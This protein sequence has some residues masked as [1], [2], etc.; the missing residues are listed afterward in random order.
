MSTNVKVAVRLRPFNQ[1][2]KERNAALCME[3]PTPQQTIITN[4]ETSK[5]YTYTFDHS[6]WLDTPQEV[7]YTDLGVPLLESAF[8]GYNATIFAYG[9]TGAG[10]SYSMTGNE[11]ARGIIPQMNK[12][13]FAKIEEAPSSMKY[14]VTV[15]FLEIYREEVK[16]LLNPSGKDLKVREHPKL[17][18]Y[19]EHLAELVVKSHQDVMRL[20]DQ[21]NHIRAVASTNMNDTSSR[22]HSVFTVKIAAKDED[23]EH[24]GYHAKINLVDLAGS[25]RQASTGATGDRLKEGA[26]I[27]KSLS[28]LGNVIN[29]LADPKKKAKFIPYRDS[30][31]TRILQESLGGNTKTVMLAALSPADINFDETHSTLQYANRAKNICNKAVKNEDENAR[32]IR[33]LREEVERLRKQVSVEGGGGVDVQSVEQMEKAI[34]DLKRAKQETWEQKE[35]LSRE[36][37]E[38]RKKTLKEK[39]LMELLMENL[40]EENEKL[41]KSMEAMREEKDKALK[42]YSTKK[43]MVETEKSSLQRDVNAYK[44]LVAQNATENEKEALL[45]KIKNSKHSLKRSSEEMKTAKKVLKAIT[46][47][48]QKCKEDIQ[49][50]SLFLQGDNELMRKL[51][52]EEVGR[53]EEENA[54]R[55][56]MERER[57]RTELEEEKARLKAEMDQRALGGVG[58]SAAEHLDL[59]MRLIEE[60][61]QISM[62][63]SQNQ[64]LEQQI[65]DLEV[66]LETEVERNGLRLERQ[67]LEYFKLFRA[68]RRYYEE[69]RV[70]LDSRYRDL[71]G[72]CINDCVELSKRKTELEEKL[73]RV[74][75]VTGYTDEEG[76]A[77]WA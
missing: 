48:Q 64:A 46:E 68:Y 56:E 23:N 49:A 63:K 52:D 72:R 22:S 75:A 30:K 1:R 43:N 9:Q 70:K 15:S 41:K 40:R 69:E 3:M 13:I 62:L 25:E 4:P 67:E 37:E 8:A 36:M 51:H 10:K 54:A 77:T 60:R 55:M 59:E 28:A 57:M 34:D 16:D 44:E 12:D 38:E 50:Q 53:L 21:G 58:I 33:E 47:K 45:Q 2:E 29:A 11:S 71:V 73:Q 19:V 26:A 17:G 18:V 7:V 20:M 32:I 42:D 14:L 39:G 76:E 66:S 6:Y 24:G 27:N 65:A 74:I 31:L 5:K 61:G 35:K